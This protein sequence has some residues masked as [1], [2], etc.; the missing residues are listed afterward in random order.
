MGFSIGAA[1]LT[2][3]SRR[4]NGILHGDSV[5][6]VTADR[7]DSGEELLEVHRMC[8]PASLVFPRSRYCG[9]C[10]TLHRQTSIHPAV[11][12]SR[13]TCRYPGSSGPFQLVHQIL[14]HYRL[15]PM[16]ALAPGRPVNSGSD[17]KRSRERDLLIVTSRSRGT[18]H[19]FSGADQTSRV[20]ALARAVVRACS[21]HLGW[22]SGVIVSLE[23]AF[24]LT[25]ICDDCTGKEPQ[26]TCMPGHR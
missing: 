14:A 13:A 4:R 20:C 1:L 22:R 11:L 16:D 9:R 21:P 3:Q 6:I 5:K 23:A 18:H 19:A 2:H 25:P 8:R 17:R 24:Q 7:H 12:A 10:A 26:A 15:S